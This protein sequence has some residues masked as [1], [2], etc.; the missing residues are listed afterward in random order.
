MRK[1]YTP[2]R[3]IFI[4]SIL[5]VFSYVCLAQNNFPV[6][7]KIT[8]ENG[9]PLESVTVQVKGT[10]LTTVTKSDGTFS[11]LAPSGNA[12]LMLSSVGFTSR[13]A[14]INNTSQLNFSMV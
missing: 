7:G 1:K 2:L 11:L 10:Q 14:P 9:K 5:L 4:L 13:E 8:D 12:V 6:T 3:E